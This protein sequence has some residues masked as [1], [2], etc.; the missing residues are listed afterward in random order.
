MIPATSTANQ[1][2]SA[3]A[4]AAASVTPLGNTFMDLLTGGSAQQVSNN[5]GPMTSGLLGGLFG[6]LTGSGAAANV[7]PSAV[8]SSLNTNQELLVNLNSYN[9]DG[10][11]ENLGNGTTNLYIIRTSLARWNEECTVLDS[12]SMHHVILLYKPRVMQALEQF[13]NDELNE[14]REKRLKE[15][16][17]K[18]EKR[19]AAAAA[20]AA[21]ANTTAVTE[22][23]KAS[24]SEEAMVSEP[25]TMEMTSMENPSSSVI[26]TPPVASESNATT[27]M[28]SEETATVNTESQD[29]VSQQQTIEDLAAQVIPPVQV[30]EQTNE[31][32]QQT[33]TESTESQVVNTQTT[34]EATTSQPQQ[35]VFQTAEER[36]AATNFLINFVGST[37]TVFTISTTAERRIAIEALRMAEYQRASQELEQATSNEATMT[38][39]QNYVFLDQHVVE[40]PS[41]IDPSFLGALPDQLRR[42]VIMEQFRIQGIDIRNRPVPPPVT[43]TQTV[44]QPSTSGTSTVPAT[45]TS[46]DTSTPATAEINPEFLAALPPQIQEELLTQQRIEQQARAAQQQNQQQAADPNAVAA[47][48]SGGAPGTAVA[49]VAE[50]DNAAF[51]RALPPSL[52]Q[53]ILFDM[54][55]SQI[56]ALPEDLAAEARQLQ[57]QHRDREIDLFAAAAAAHHRSASRFSRGAG[58]AGLRIGGS[59]RGTGGGAAAAAAAAGLEGIYNVA[60][61]LLHDTYMYGSG[62]TGAGANRDLSRLRRGLR[63]LNDADF[64][65]NNNTLNP[66]VNLGSG[67]ANGANAASALER[68]AA[69]NGRQLLDHESLACLLVLL[70]IDDARMNMTKLHRVVRNLCIHGPSRAWVIRALLSILEKVSGK[71]ELSLEQQ[72]TPQRLG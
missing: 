63:Q 11:G 54:D 39:P 12:H 49:V 14:K 13:R 69:R 27:N 35:P 18:Q 52:R 64:I 62:G 58:G 45:T 6:G 71:Q 16:K 68:A 20:S 22:T 28:D 41:G 25:S 21:T 46:A 26:V 50:D 2:L 38:Y 66:T 57:Q 3:A 9:N 55:H 44:Q 17:E 8:V 30:E 7:N 48:T 72:K 51:M 65:F 24:T 5:V 10:F 32:V 31:P 33:V 29:Q 40:L 42:E 37:C 47:T 59:N 19:A 70:F 4:A 61:S 23:Q 1:L 67:G 15:E 53:A 43:N 56:G 36:E 60:S 34:Q